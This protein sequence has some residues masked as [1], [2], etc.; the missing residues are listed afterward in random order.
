LSSSLLFML[1]YHRFLSVNMNW[2]TLFIISF[3]HVKKG[4]LQLQPPLI[5]QLLQ[6]I[7][8]TKT[9]YF[10]KRPNMQRKKLPQ[11]HPLFYLRII[12]NKSVLPTL[13]LFLEQITWSL[14]GCYW[15]KYTKQVIANDGKNSIL[16]SWL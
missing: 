2:M 15:K 13:H 12:P 1:K 11:W 8:L 5:P 4:C 3:A 14:K 6:Y 10:E 9:P 16:I 7:L